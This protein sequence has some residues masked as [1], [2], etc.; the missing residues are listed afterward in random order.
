MRRSQF[1]KL[2]GLSQEAFDLA[3]ARKLL[4][5]RGRVTKPGWQDFSV[6]DAVALEAAT[7]LFVR[8]MKKSDARVAVDAYFDLALEWA[9]SPSCKGPTYIGTAT[10]FAVID[11]FAIAGDQHQL[12]GSAQDIADETERLQ[13]ALGER[14]H[15][16]G[17]ITTNLNLCVET[18]ASRAVLAGI[19][20]PRINELSKLFSCLPSVA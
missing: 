1:L 19:E 6:D 17:M 13:V 11:G 18:V 12:I 8:G 7:S 10:S 20:D 2:A 14:H 16:G 5:L 3:R 4:P 9:A 15:L